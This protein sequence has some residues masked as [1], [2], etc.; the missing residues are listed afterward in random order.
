MSEQNK[1]MV[2]VEDG[3]VIEGAGMVALGFQGEITEEGLNARMKQ[4]V[5]GKE[6]YHYREVIPCDRCGRCTILKGFNKRGKMITKGCWCERGGFEVSMNA[7][8][9]AAYSTGKVRMMVDLENAP[10]GVVRDRER[11]VEMIVGGKR[12][13]EVEKQTEPEAIDYRGGSGMYKR[14]EVKRVGEE[15]REGEGMP[16]RLMN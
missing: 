4:I 7:T 14:G 12:Y 5:K 3:S 10:G 8:C 9:D 6:Y 2:E 1:V 15:G 13:E 11:L 16:R